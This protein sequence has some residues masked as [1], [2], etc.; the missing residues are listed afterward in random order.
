MI[1]FDQICPKR[2]LSVENG[3]I[4]LV[5]AFMV[6][7]CYVKLLLTR[8][9][10]H[11][12]ILMSLLVLVAVTISLSSNVE[13]FEVL[14]AVSNIPFKPLN[15]FSK[16]VLV[17]TREHEVLIWYNVHLSTWLV[18]KWPSKGRRIHFY[19]WIRSDSPA[20]FHLRV[21]ILTNLI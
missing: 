2:E 11:N 16:L 1:F 8:A 5:R 19:A 20:G 3:R 6:V 7:T 10:R 21:A 15:E 13:L 17:I 4:T 12:S 14:M 18:L 9:D